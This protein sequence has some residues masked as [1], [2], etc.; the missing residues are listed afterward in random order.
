MGIS[1]S[2]SFLNMELETRNQLPR[3]VA[4]VL[5]VT[6]LQ[7]SFQRRCSRA[8]QFPKKEQSLHVRKRYGRILVDIFCT[9]ADRSQHTAL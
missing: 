4:A 8:P 1:S 3:H 7:V 6:S 9:A 2:G 5:C